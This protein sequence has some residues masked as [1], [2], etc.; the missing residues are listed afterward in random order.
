MALKDVDEVI[1]GYPWRITRDLII[2]LKI[3]IVLAG[4]V[5][6]HENYNVGSSAASEEYADAAE[7][8]KLVQFTSPNP[9]TSA[10]IIARIA[11]SRSRFEE[12]FA[13]KALA[14]EKYKA[15]KAYVEEA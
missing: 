7:V 15:G 8:G 3:D 12:K 10:D 11:A 6:E 9:M 1:I 5:A 4:S 2:S 14:E 13:R